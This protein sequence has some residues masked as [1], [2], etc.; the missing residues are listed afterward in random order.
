MSDWKKK[1]LARAARIA[2][3]A[4]KRAHMARGESQAAKIN[5]LDGRARRESLRIQRIEE[6][7]LMRIKRLKK[8]DELLVTGRR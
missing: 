1:K 3:N 7:E 2:R 8:A 5:K 4:D 6:R